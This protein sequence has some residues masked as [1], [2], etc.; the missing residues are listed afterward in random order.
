V[1]A[2]PPAS[3]LRLVR[4]RIDALRHQP[5]A[6]TE[7]GFGTIA[8]DR[9]V[10][11][12]SLAAER[13]A[14][15]GGE[16]TTPLLV[17]RETALAHN[18]IAM[19]QWCTSAGVLLAP[20]G[21]TT[22]APQ[23]FERQLAAG[24]WAMTAATI[25]QAQVYRS[26]GVHRILIANELTDR[27]GIAW[28]A[29]ELTADPDWEC[30]AY[31][32]SLAGV[33]MLSET[34]TA[35][36]ANRPLR[37]LVEL[38]FPGGRT[39]CRGVAEALSVAA[40]VSEADALALA[41]ASGYEG[42]IGHDAEPETLAAVA[43]YCGRLRALGES[44]AASR[45][46][47]TSPG[48]ITTG[49][50]VSAGGSAYF[51]V[52]ARELT[53]GD[54]AGGTS[55]VVLRSGCYLTHDHGEYAAVGPASR[56][57]GPD[58]IPAIELWAPVLSCPEPG[59]ALACAG[60]RDVSFDQGMPVPLRLRRL[61]GTVEPASV[62]TATRLDDQHAYIRVPPGFALAPGDLICFGVSHPCTTLDKWRV[63]PVVDDDY[64]VVDAVHTFF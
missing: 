59:L 4:E 61:D 43:D 42:G 54:G 28:L 45:P 16:F 64:R 5:I 7:K 49:P 14:A 1:D 15:L 31:V 41:G 56:R 53:A 24:A 39:G 35:A 48:P 20:H 60:R 17:L 50:I 2:S 19:A 34:L 3:R 11:A 18:A 22:M 21:K 36:G 44:L 57:L 30:F 8:A 58:L 51:D 9:T 62:L 12:A 29:A 10:S 26:F 52:V 25:S 32:D 46:V 6:A 38:G 33:R 27:A 55:L 40:A 13:P 63:I 37:V 47:P 23:L